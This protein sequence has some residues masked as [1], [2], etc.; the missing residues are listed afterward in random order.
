MIHVHHFFDEATSTLTYVV[1]DPKTRDAVVIDPV[2]DYDPA[3]SVYA[4]TSIDAVVAYCTDN[5]LKV[6]YILETHAHTDHLSGIK[7]APIPNSMQ[8]Q[9]KRR[10]LHCA[11]PA[12]L[13]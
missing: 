7:N 13:R 11:I 6:H 3:S 8:Q 1:S 4:T 2:L 12:M 9:P 5:L 10:L